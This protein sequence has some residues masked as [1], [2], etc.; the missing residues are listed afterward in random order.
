[1]DGAFLDWALATFAGDVAADELSEGPYWVLS[2]VDKRQ[3]K[4]IL[5]GLESGGHRARPLGHVP[6]HVGA[7]PTVV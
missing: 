4:R 7:W 6:T 5:S 3:Y 1:M 2:A